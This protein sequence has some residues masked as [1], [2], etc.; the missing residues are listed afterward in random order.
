[1]KLSRLWLVASFLLG[2]SVV[3][4]GDLSLLLTQDSQSLGADGV[5]RTAHFQERVYRQ[6]NQVWVERVM[7]PHAHEL[8]EQ[9]HAKE[10]HKHLD[11]EASA[12]WISIDSQ[13]KVQLRLVN[14]YDKQ[15]VV[16]PSGDYDAVGFDGRWDSAYYLMDPRKIQGF[17]QSQR[18]APQ[19]A[20]WY[21]SPKGDHY[22]RVLWDVNN[23]Y[24]QRIES[25]NTIGTVK[26]V[27]QAQVLTQPK[28]WPWAVLKGYQQKEFSDFL[29]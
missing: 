14:R 24:P 5:S 10:E 2:P 11:V 9:Q 3:W 17:V 25:G 16:V 19:G 1:M 23:E 4:A 8:G 27:M 18:P 26:R 12:H 22:I 20:V 6:T 21:E 15:I 28:T 7:P 13:Q 29:D